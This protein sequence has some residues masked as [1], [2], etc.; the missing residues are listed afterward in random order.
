MIILGIDPGTQVTGFG[1]VM[2]TKS[3]LTY[4]DSGIIELSN[5]WSLFQKLEKIYDSI[6]DL[7]ELHKPTECA[8]ENIFY[9]QNVNSALKLGHARGAAILGALHHNLKVAEYSP[10]EMK[11]AVVG[12]GNAAKEQVQF[13]VKQI[14]NLK[15]EMTLDESDGLGLAICHAHRLGS[16]RAS[17]KSWTAFIKMHPERVK[18]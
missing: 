6:V 11:M 9:S 13:M 1:V 8:I 18:K 3:K 15:L 16:P 5:K 4:V 7:V 2:L 10:K 12:N 14:L 17:V